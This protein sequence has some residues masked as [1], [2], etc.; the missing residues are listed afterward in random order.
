MSNA[1]QLND[2]GDGI[3]QLVLNRPP[4]NAMSIE[5]LGELGGTMSKLEADDSVRAVVISSALGLFSAGLDLKEI[6]D[7]T[8][9]E[10]TAL[11][12]GLNSAFYHIYGFKK[13]VV[14]AING[15]AVAGGMFFALAADYTV[16]NE[17]SR[18]GL[19]EI[20]VGVNFPVAPYEIAKA[21]LSPGSFRRVLLSGRLFKA[22]AALEMQVIDE[23][24]PDD[25]LLDRAVAVAKEYAGNPPMAYAAIKQQIRAEPLANM[26]AAVDNKTDS[27][28]S[29]WFTDETLSAMD[30]ILAATSASK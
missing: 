19:T 1:I 17:K 7:F 23:I 9:Y 27:T 14:S 20:K 12:D 2:L 30:A 28:R 3:T 26:K 11:V 22:E 13:P 18:F 24:A 8:P 4:A 21:E 5:V 29:G 10:Q 16:A 6:K 25:Q 15:A